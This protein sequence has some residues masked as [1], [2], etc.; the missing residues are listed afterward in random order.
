[1]GALI[2]N[3]ELRNYEIDYKRRDGRKISMLLNCSVARDR[4]EDITDIIFGAIDITERKLA[5]EDRK[6]FFPSEIKGLRILIVE[7]NPTNLLILQ[8]MVSAWELLPTG[9]NNGFSALKELK[10]AMERG[11]P[12]RLIILDRNLPDMDGFEVAEKIKKNPD[13]ADIPVIL[14]PSDEGKDD[15]R[16]AKDMGISGILLKP[17]RRLKLYDSMMNTLWSI[18]KEEVPE[19]RKVES[20]LKGNPLKILLSEDNLVNQKLAVKLLEKQGWEV[21]VAGNGKEAVE[22]IERDGFDLVLMDVQMPEMDG[23]EATRVIREK[24]KCSGKHIPIIALTAH[25]MKKDRNACLEAGMDSYISK[26]IKVK[27]LFEEIEKLMSGS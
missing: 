22:L 19:R 4:N 1:M 16:R 18:K 15:R 11:N 7:G 13:Y 23:I 9:V 10:L 25:A 27:E 14:L 21:M 6:Q 20:S 2:K 17:V 5:E 26:P 24:E 12:Y 8:E 3:G